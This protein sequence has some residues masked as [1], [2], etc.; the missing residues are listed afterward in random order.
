LRCV[1]AARAANV[2]AGAAEIGATQRNAGY[3]LD[4]HSAIGVLAARRGLAADPSTPVIALGTAHPAKFPAAVRA[5]SGITP[6]LPE[7]LAD[8]MERR[9][10]LTLLPNNQAEIED[11]VRET[12]RAVRGAAA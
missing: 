11:F 12:A 4:P 2:A 10:R 1:F 8:L 9:E 7:H 3:L 5:A 6:K